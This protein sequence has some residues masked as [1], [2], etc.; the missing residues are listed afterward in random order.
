[1]ICLF[2][3][4]LLKRNSRQKV[5]LKWD[6]V[7][8]SEPAVPN[9]EWTPLWKV[10]GFERSLHLARVIFKSSLFVQVNAFRA[11]TLLQGL[12][13]G[14]CTYYVGLRWKCPQYLKTDYSTWCPLDLAIWKSII[15]WPLSALFY[16]THTNTG[17]T[18][19]GSVTSFI[20]CSKMT[21]IVDWCQRHAGWFLQPQQTFN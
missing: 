10:W 12:I 18:F 15:S 14:F 7:A 9:V 1:M 21:Q 8:G 5:L 13:K 6:I 4:L 17:V 11:V 19:L 3:K 2:S 20:I 16:H